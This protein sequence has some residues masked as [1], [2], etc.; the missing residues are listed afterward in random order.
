MAAVLNPR[1]PAFRER[2]L[3]VASISKKEALALILEEPNLLRRPLV[4]H[5]GKAILGYDAAEYDRLP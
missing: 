3:D 4:L 1:S 2:N 5:K